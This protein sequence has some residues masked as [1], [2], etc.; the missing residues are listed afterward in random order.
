[1]KSHPVIAI[2]L[3]CFCI[4][5]C[6]GDEAANMVDYKILH[7]TIM[8]PVDHSNPDGPRLKQYV[9]ILIPDG[10]P[11]D[12][13]VFFNL[14][15]E[16][17]ATDD[18][19]RQFHQ[20]H[21][22]R[23]DIIYIQAE[24]RGYGQSITDDENQSVPSYIRIEE[25]LA[26][27]HEVVSQLK[28]DYS[29]PWMAAG[30]SY[31]GGLVI[32]YAY[33][34]P[35]DV[36]VVLSSSGVVDWPFMDYGYDRQV[37]ETLG[38]ACYNRLAEHAANLKPEETFD[39]NWL[40]RD[41][42]YATAQGVVQYP[43]LKKLQPFFKVLTFLPTKTLVKV[44]HRMDDRFGDGEAWKYARA[45]GAT[46]VGPAEIEEG[47][48]NWHAWRYQMCA[49][50]GGFLT[51]EKPDGLFTRT[52]EDF[53]EECRV[54][55]GEEPMAAT[56]PEWS[57]REMTKELKVPLVYVTGGMDPWLSV[58]LEPDFEIKNG[59]YFFVPEGRHCPERAD[60]ELAQ[61]VLAEM[62]KYARAEPQSVK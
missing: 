2:F 22:R 34:Y 42:L 60:P 56:N 30:W 50:I 24:H 4:L 3:I 49:E 5:S 35:D 23:K 17:D 9:D 29:G 18:H 19:L 52:Q 8:Q 48:H 47:L 12:S 14:G 26:D 41:F 46:N 43:N 13:P 54:Q 1:M 58:S 7:R 16:T 39:Q 59:K 44:L 10:A 62:L 36:A 11:L 40:D 61:Q 38:E 15:N 31:G 32:E 55:F 37:R 20:R 28:E 51:S 6:G 21:N 57:Q 45:T 53:C 33:R 25:V 27:T